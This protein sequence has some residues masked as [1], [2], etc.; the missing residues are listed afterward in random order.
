MP[1]KPAAN[2]TTWALWIDRELLARFRAVVPRGERQDAVRA[3]IAV[4]VA[5]REKRR[6]ERDKSGGC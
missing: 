2:K 5:D 1:N 4:L 3:A 6:E